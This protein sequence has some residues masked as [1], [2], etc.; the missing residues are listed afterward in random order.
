MTKERVI[1]LCCWLLGGIF[2]FSG[3]VKCVD[4]VGTAVFVEKYLA[5]FSLDALLPIA[6]PIAVVLSV[7]EFTLGQLLLSGKPHRIT[8]IATVVI[9]SLFTIVTL[10]NATILPIGDC[11]CFG[12]AIRLTPLQTLL[13][14]ILMLP[15]AI[16][17]IA[18]AQ[19]GH[20]NYIALFVPI[21]ISL[22]ISLYALRYQ[23]IIDFM[24][25]DRDTN[26]REDVAEQ[27]A[28]LEESTINILIF[29]DKVSGN[30][31]EFDA[32]NIECWS[33]PNLEYVDSRTIVTNDK[34]LP[35][36]EFVVANAA[37]EDVTLD[38]LERSGR[39]AWVT[40]YDDLSFERHLQLIKSFVESHSYDS[41]V[42]V[43]SLGAQNVSQMLGVEC[44]DVD[45]MTLRTMNRS[46]VGVIVVDNGVIV[47]KSDIRDI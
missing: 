25:Y 40:I 14:N 19:R 46:K 30:M 44:Y 17:L 39:V 9:M 7:V 43:T 38:L 35:L 32:S 34:Y 41:Y 11:G 42:V 10:L 36:A 29:K 6:L 12:D 15:L 45:A 20:M 26:L 23:P 2:S 22:G 31:V 1:N 8:A 13:K 37:G 16:L 5:T 24:P 3:I 33:N 18:G 21:I 27:R 47:D 28:Q 4:P